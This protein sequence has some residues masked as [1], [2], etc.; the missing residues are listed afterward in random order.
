MIKK[1]NILETKINILEIK[2]NIL[3]FICLSA[4]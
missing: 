4:S 1:I 2:R 3:I